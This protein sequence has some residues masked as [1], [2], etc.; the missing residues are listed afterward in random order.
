MPPRIEEYHASQAVRR[1]RD[2]RHRRRTQHLGPAR[3]CAVHPIVPVAPATVV[4]VPSAAGRSPDWIKVKNRSARHP[5]RR[6]YGAVMLALT[7]SIEAALLFRLRSVLDQS[8]FTAKGSSYLFLVITLHG[9]SPDR[10]EKC[11][12]NCIFHATMFH[13][14]LRCGCRTRKRGLK[15]FGDEL[16]R[17]T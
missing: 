4:G 6:V 17:P 16:R 10:W 7:V 15:A 11:L 9:P 1:H 14:N 13:R 12:N 8:V 2:P 5:A 3:A